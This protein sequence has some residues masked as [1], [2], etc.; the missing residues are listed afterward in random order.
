V[1]C[2]RWKDGEKLSAAQ[3]I[4][5]YS[6]RSGAVISPERL[7]SAVQKMMRYNDWQDLVPGGGSMAGLYTRPVHLRPALACVAVVVAG[8]GLRGA[9]NPGQQAAPSS[10]AGAIRLI[11]QGDDM[12]AAHGINVATIEAYTH[13]ILRSANVIVPG[14]WLPEAA[15]LLKENPGIDAGVHLALTS[16]WSDV[17]W[18]PLTHAPSL[19]DEHGFFFPM[20]WPRADFPAHTDLKSNSPDLGEIER[21]QIALARAMIPRVTYTWAHMGFTSLS[22]D[23]AALATRLTKEYGLVTPGPDIGIRMIG[24]VW[25]GTDPPNARIDKLV[26]KLE[27]LEPG[28][29]LM[30]DHVAIDTPETRAI[31]H[32][33]YEYVAADRSAV[34]AAWT[35]EKVMD[36]VTRRG[37]LLTNYT[38]LLSRK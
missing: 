2:T 36:V 5:D 11:V 17:K 27:A 19:V 38:E 22:A 18:R 16:E 6:A 13:G 4:L 24:G 29:W 9:P 21:A 3:R 35:S 26:A 14:P 33:N 7:A 15:R 20:V 1:K 28:T 12:A 8:V 10:T 32:K 31:G 23:V 37:I 30:V 25:Q 34:L